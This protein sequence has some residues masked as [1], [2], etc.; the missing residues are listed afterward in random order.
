MQKIMFYAVELPP[1]LLLPV[2]F[3]ARNTLVPST[4]NTSCWS[5]TSSTK[6]LFSP[7]G[8]AAAEVA[9]VKVPVRAM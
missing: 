1:W 7:A 5:S 2:S 3:L 6:L 9:A 4:S 8:T